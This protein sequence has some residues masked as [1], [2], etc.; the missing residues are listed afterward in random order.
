MKLTSLLVFLLLFWAVRACP[1]D[2]GSIFQS[3]VSFPETQAIDMRKV[4]VCGEDQSVWAISDAGKVYYKLSSDAVFT[5]FAT[6]P[7][8]FVTDIAGYNASEMYFLAGDKLYQVKNMAALTEIVLPGSRQQINGIA[9]VHASRNTYLE[10]YHGKRDWLAIAT[11]TLAHSLFR[12]DGTFASFTPVSTGSSPDIEISNSSLKSIDFQYK[13]HPVSQCFGNLTTAYYNRVDTVTTE[14]LLPESSP[15]YDGIVNCTYFEAP[16]NEEKDGGKKGFDY[17]GTNKGLFV[18][19]SGSCGLAE[20]R[21]KLDFNINDLEELNFFRDIF[22][23]KIVLAGANDGLYYSARS[24]SPD[25]T[26]EIDK[27]GFTKLFDFERR[28]NSIALELAGVEEGDKLFCQTAV[29][30]ATD[31]GIVK[32]PMAPATKNVGKD[33]FGRNGLLVSVDAGLKDA[34][35]VSNGEEYKFRVNLP[36]SNPADYLVQW[37]RDPE[38]YGD[39]IEIDSLQGLTEW[40]LSDRGMYSIKIT[41]LSCGEYV[42][43]G[44]FYLRDPE[45]TII[46]FNY[47]DTVSMLKGCKFTFSA[48]STTPGMKY[49]WFRNDQPLS[50]TSNVLKAELPGRYQLF[51]IDPCTERPMPMKSVQLNEVEVPAPVIT[52]S[53]NLSLCY[54]D[55]VTLSVED[56]D[57]DGITFTYRWQRNGSVIPGETSREIKVSQAGN[58]DATINL[59]EDCT[60]PRSPTAPVEI[61]ELL[62]LE[63]PAQTQICTIRGQNLKL[64]AAQGFMTYTWDGVAGTSNFLEV[65]AP[66]EYFLEVEDASGCTAS[67]TYIVVPYCAPPVPPNAFSPNGDGVNDLWTVAGLEDD[68]DAK[69]HVYNRFGVSVFDGSAKQPFWNGKVKG[70]DV[71]D[72]TYYYVVTKKSA[73]PLT[74]SLVL[75]R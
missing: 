31:K 52:R 49:Q 21:R 25:V 42:D 57:I 4:I 13:V 26:S 75:I 39:R 48:T 51:Y 54:G 15:V 41:L 62:K 2:V 24:F 59:G 46:D 28:V 20:V 38:N 35:C 32:I 29:W 19:T 43:V 45:R 34:Y 33:T 61:N 67:T 17:W 58:Y 16:F 66:G 65:T 6:I 9:V 63:A 72:G 56:P 11:Y 50:E 55:T 27:I 10:G 30:L 69:I 40:T 36:G 70:A 71:P 74:G 18:K 12:D 73:K 68:P 7:N 44:P 5:P 23:D 14:T 22:N 47:P 53:K 8:V 3:R 1:Q 37:Y 64:T 60:G